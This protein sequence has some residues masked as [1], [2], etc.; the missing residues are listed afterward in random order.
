MF[1]TVDLCSVEL[2]P[3]FPDYGQRY[4]NSVRLCLQIPYFYVNCHQSDADD[5]PTGMFLLSHV[6][7]LTEIMR[8]QTLQASGARLLSPDRLNHSGDWQLEE[9]SSIWVG[10]EQSDAGPRLAHVFEVSGGARYLDAVHT[11]T[12]AGIADLRLL[13]RF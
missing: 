3:L 10:T 2:P 8:D 9:L 1:S 13:V 7:Q 4:W 5:H 12:E 6:D 11:S